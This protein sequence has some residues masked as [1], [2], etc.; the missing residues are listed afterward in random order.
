MQPL[1]LPP[2]PAPP[3]LR[4][5]NVDYRERYGFADPEQYV[6]KAPRG[7]SHEVVAMISGIKHEPEWMR[8]FRHQALDLFLAKPMPAWGDQAM[9]RQIDFDQIY[10]YIRPTAEQ[11]R[12][13]SDV[14]AGIKS[15]FERLG[16]PEAERKF[17]A[18]VSAQYE[19]EVVYH[20]IRKDLEAK[21]V[22]FSDMVVKPAIS[23]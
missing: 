13:W 7:L 10:Y 14:P 6:L 22:I 18:G 15:T 3:A 4:D 16:I 11:G 9:L 19:S 12:N 8:A 20:S 17:L 2:P 5:I 23:I 1:P 21:G